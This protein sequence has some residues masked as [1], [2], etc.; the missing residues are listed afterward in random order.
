MMVDLG[1]PALIL[2]GG[3]EVF[4]LLLQVLNAFSNIF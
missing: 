2:K 3:A 4:A 1:G